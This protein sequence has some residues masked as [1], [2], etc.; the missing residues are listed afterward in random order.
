M[1]ESF[2][3][4]GI[5]VPGFVRTSEVKEG[6][7]YDRKILDKVTVEINKAY[8]NL[9]VSPVFWDGPIMDSGDFHG[10]YRNFV[11]RNDQS[12]V[13]KLFL[14]EFTFLQVEE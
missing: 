13:F 11:L 3:F 6:S 2:L 14:V 5:P 10:V 8:E 7:S 9:Y 12:E 4:F 1:F